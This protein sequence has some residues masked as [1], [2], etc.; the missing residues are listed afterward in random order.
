MRRS[1]ALQ[2]TAEA[3]L[4]LARWNAVMWRAGSTK[5]WQRVGET[6]VPDESE[7]GTPQGLRSGQETFAIE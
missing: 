7:C 3:D 2:A 4:Q 1:R 6:W 5:C